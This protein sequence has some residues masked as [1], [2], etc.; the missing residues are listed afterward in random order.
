MK[1]GKRGLTS[2]ADARGCNEG[3]GAYVAPKPRWCQPVASSEEHQA[4][5]FVW[6]GSLLMINNGKDRK[7]NRK[8]CETHLKVRLALKKDVGKFRTIGP[9]EPIREYVSGT[10]RE[11]ETLNG[12]GMWRSRKSGRSVDTPK[13][14]TEVLSMSDEHPLEILLL[15]QTPLQCRGT[16]I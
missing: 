10:F 12:T 5:C 11:I 14:P 3:G 2:L 7:S 6:P 1:F 13:P 15:A 9:F 8:T 4:N 16:R